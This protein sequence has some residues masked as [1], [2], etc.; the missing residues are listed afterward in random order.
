MLILSYRQKNVQLWFFNHYIDTTTII[1]VWKF[2]ED[3]CGVLNEWPSHWS[4]ILNWKCSM[5]MNN[6]L[7]GS[8]CNFLNQLYL[9]ALK[10]CLWKGNIQKGATFKPNLDWYCH[11]PECLK[12]NAIHFQLVEIN[13]CSQTSSWFSSHRRQ[14]WIQ[15]N[16][17]ISVML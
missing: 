2:L 15:Q 6:I 7:S 13:K 5:L 17:V 3:N 4:L 1:I 12:L 9:F 8:T 11:I 16:Y 14:N 10:L